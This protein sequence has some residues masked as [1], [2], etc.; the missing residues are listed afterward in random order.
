MAKNIIF[1][2]LHFGSALK[3]YNDDLYYTFKKDRFH[4]TKDCEKETKGN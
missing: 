4:P 3:F 2:Y 1:F